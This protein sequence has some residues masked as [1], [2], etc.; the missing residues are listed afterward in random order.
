[1]TNEAAIE[2]IEWKY[3]GIYSFYNIQ[4]D[5]DVLDEFL[6]PFKW[7]HYAAIYEDEDLVGYFTFNPLNVYEVEIGLGLH[8]DIMGKGKGLS[9]VEYAIEI[10]LKWY[11]PKK[12]IVN[13]AEFNQRAIRLY[14]KLGFE[15]ISQFIKKINGNEYSFVRLERETL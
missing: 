6:N 14:E 5:L 10:A 1:M 9:F 3:D 13:I 12:M 2:I 7:N 4:N 8:P 11:V 15:K